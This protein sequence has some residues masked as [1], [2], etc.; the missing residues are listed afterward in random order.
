MTPL[1]RQLVDDGI[2]EPGDQGWRT[3]RRWQGAMARASLAL[4][5][6]GEPREDLRIPVAE[7]LL[8]IYGAEL[9]D[10]ELF[11]MI[12]VILPVEQSLLSQRADPGASPPGP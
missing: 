2:L 11:S 9:T 12:Q 1:E 3:G 5:R 10:A 4:V 6:R 7:A 8:Q